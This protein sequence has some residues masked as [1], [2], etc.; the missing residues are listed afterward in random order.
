MFDGDIALFDEY[1][2]GIDNPEDGQHLA[3]RIGN[4]TAILLASHGVIVV[5]ETIQQATYRAVTFERTCRLH[6]DTLAA[7]RTPKL[8][9]QSMRSKLKRSLN[10]ISVDNFWRGEVRRLLREE[11][12]V[13]GP[14][15]DIG[16]PETCSSRC[17][18]E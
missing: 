16:A 1:T 3:R 4:A 14:M 10:T 5:G 2:G 18:T 12:E 11:P 6:Y 8:V 13:L 17:C 7:G 15:E 9:P